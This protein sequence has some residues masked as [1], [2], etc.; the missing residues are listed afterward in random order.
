LHLILSNITVGIEVYG[1]IIL[2]WAWKYIVP[3]HKYLA[4]YLITVVAFE[5]IYI[6]SDQFNPKYNLLFGNIYSLIE[7]WLLSILYTQWNKEKTAIFY[8]FSLIHFLIWSVFYLSNGLLCING[9]MGGMG[10]FVVIIMSFIAYIRYLKFEYKSF[11]IP[12]ALGFI[13]YTCTNIGI[14]SFS[15]YL[16]ALKSEKYFLL[17]ASINLISNFGLYLFMTIGLIKCKKQSLELSLY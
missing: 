2:A 13:F 10:S 15:A 16:N 5:C 11:K 6:V 9:V 7:V 17:Y 14:L 1:L 8:L 3:Q 12:I 4:V